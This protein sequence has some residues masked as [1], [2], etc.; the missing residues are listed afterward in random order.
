[1]KV[2]LAG[3]IENATRAINA[4]ERG[5]YGVCLSELQRHIEELCRGEHTLAEFAEFYCIDT[6]PKPKGKSDEH[7]D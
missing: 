3:L 1:M 6:T 2:S 4:R 7:H 5:Y